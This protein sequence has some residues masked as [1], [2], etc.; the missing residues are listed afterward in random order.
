MLA[1]KMPALP[2]GDAILFKG[3]PSSKTLDVGGPT[4]LKNE[5][6]ARAFGE[7]VLEKIFCLP[8]E[9]CASQS[10]INLQVKL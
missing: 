9:S 8:G 1:G 5:R 6:L 7:R 2:S 4:F 3:K 10:K